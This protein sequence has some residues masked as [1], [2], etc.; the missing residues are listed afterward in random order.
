MARFVS[1]VKR[2]LVPSGKTPRTILGGPFQG[3]RMSL[4]L[5]CQSQLYL[6]L[7][8]RELYKWLK[9]LSRGINTAVD[10][11]AGEG[12]YTLYFLFK[13]SAKKVFAFEPDAD[14]R[15][16]LMSNLE[17]NELADSSRLVLSSKFVGAFDKEDTCTLDALLPSILPPCLIKM[18]VDGG[19][20]RI[21]QGASRLLNVPQVSWIIETH[22][23]QLEED[24]IRILRQ[25]GFRTTIVRNAW[26][27]IFIP[28]LR[29]SLH[30]RWLIA[31]KG[32]DMQ[33]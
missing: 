22:S 18:D 3:L 23:Q 24:C 9:R 29:P 17:L 15:A 21:L 33:A 16:R 27:R 19:E 31:V 28:E 10:I 20:V 6:G 8:E 2:L 12:E 11:G 14:N 4:D 26:W 13:S 7:F 25:A 1:R 5:T 30:N 32:R